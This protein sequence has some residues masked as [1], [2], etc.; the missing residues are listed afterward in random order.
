MTRKHYV[1]G[2]V[3]AATGKPA[4]IV[5]AIPGKWVANNGLKQY[6]CDGWC[7]RDFENGDWY[8]KQ[9]Q[10][11]DLCETCAA[12]MLGVRREGSTAFDERPGNADCFHDPCNWSPDDCP[13]QDCYHPSRLP[14]PKRHA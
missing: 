4:V 8:F 7:R 14:A 13:F 9:D 11:G 1:M 6:P 12:T 5:D 3:D 2:F 10:V